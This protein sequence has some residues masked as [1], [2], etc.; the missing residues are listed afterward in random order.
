MRARMRRR[1][2]FAGPPPGAVGSRRVEWPRIGATEGAAL[3]NRNAEVH[4]RMVAAVIDREVPIELLAP[5]FHMENH[6]AAAIDYSYRGASGWREWMSDLFECFGEGARYRN[7]EI[8]AVGEDLVAAMFCVEG[9]SVRSGNWLVFRWAAVT[10]FHDGQATHAVGYSS[11]TAALE[12]VEL[13]LEI[14]GCDDLVS[15][16]DRGSLLSLIRSQPCV[17]E[18]ARA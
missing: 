4:A 11:R 15:P 13:H 12:A 10:W 9:P 14:V 8:L 7:E 1:P 16:P 18:R 6:A 3:C 17:C 2:P 5:G